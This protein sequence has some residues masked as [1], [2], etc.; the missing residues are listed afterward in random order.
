M[1][2][3]IATFNLLTAQFEI[4]FIPDFSQDYTAA[5]KILGAT[6]KTAYLAGMYIVSELDLKIENSLS[7]RQKHIPQDPYLNRLK[8][9]KAL[10]GTSR[11]PGTLYTV[12]N[13]ET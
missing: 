1:I 13:Q 6:R 4:D 7:F 9:S 2:E 12:C 5:E 10:G 3:V 11:I 8:Q